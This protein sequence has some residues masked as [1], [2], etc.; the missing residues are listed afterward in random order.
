MY[1]KDKAILKILDDTLSR[2]EVKHKGRVFRNALKRLPVIDAVEVCRC[3]DCELY[4][5]FNSTEGRCHLFNSLRWCKDYCSDGKK[6]G[7]AEG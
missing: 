2:P 1:Y 5:P 4:R 6:K 7:S 3:K